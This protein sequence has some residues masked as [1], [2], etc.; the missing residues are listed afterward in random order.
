MMRR[1]DMTHR[2]A[3][4]AM[5]GWAVGVM[6]AFALAAWFSWWLVGDADFDN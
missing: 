1:Q 4:G 2:M 3:Q 6:I 5:I